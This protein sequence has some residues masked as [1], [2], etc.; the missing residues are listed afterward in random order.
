[1]GGISWKVLWVLALL[2]AL[3]AAHAAEL[4]ASLWFAQPPTLQGPVTLGAAEGVLLLEEAVAA[5]APLSLSWSSARYHAL[6][7]RGASTTG[8]APTTLDPGETPQDLVLAAGTL[9]G[10][11]CAEGCRVA[12]EAKGRGLVGLSGEASGALLDAT[13]PDPVVV[14]AGDV[15]VILA[16]WARAFHE[17]PDEGALAG[18]ARVAW[19]SGNLT[20]HLW[21]VSGTLQEE[22]GPARQ[23]WAGRRDEPA[24]AGLPA[25]VTRYE[26]R[27]VRIELTDARLD[28]APGAA[29]TLL[30]PRLRADLSGALDAPRADGWAE[31][32]GRRV[33]VHAAPVRADGDLLLQ[34]APG[35]R[36]DGPAARR[37]DA[38]APRPAAALHGNGT[39][40]VDGRVLAAP[41]ARAAEVAAIL[42][43]ATAG[44]ALL[45]LLK[46]GAWVWLYTRVTRA[47]VLEN[48]TRRALC[49]LIRAR[50]GA[51]VSE[52]SRA[53]GVGRVVL[54]HHLRMLEAHHLLVPCAQGRVLAYFPPGHVPSGDG[55]AARVALKDATRR[56]VLDATAGRL[57]GGATQA[58]IAQV[59]TL[60][61]RLVS[62]HLARLEAVGLVQGDGGRP[63]RFRAAQA[64]APVEPSRAGG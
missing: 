53:L 22:G 63:Q 58:E 28:A 34:M 56:R 46:S 47:Q 42:G 21:G 50:P 55:L 40:R 9:S 51:H 18:P 8:P 30:A 38:L 45:L 17:S 49:D 32:D 62:Y 64:R 7:A 12:L 61:Q 48:P 33:D 5:G 60:S 3:P 25:P 2:G 31:A 36:L 59:T 1:M 43:A 27:Q 23:V 41:A 26:T 57:D 13:D 29:A 4:R 24:A 19:A 11:A 35:E 15:R 6:V 14:G 37:A 10:L 44:I 20:L 16:A 52:L 54:Q 39:L